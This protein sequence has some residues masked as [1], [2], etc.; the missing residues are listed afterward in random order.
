[1][2]LHE[3]NLQR[4]AADIRAQ[5]GEH[6]DG[7]FE[8]T[9]AAI[10]CAGCGATKRADGPDAPR[11]LEAMLRGWA[12]SNGEPGVPDLCPR[13][14]TALNAAHARSEARAAL[15]RLGSTIRRLTR[16]ESPSE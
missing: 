11:A 8:M 5:I 3:T 10:V 12:I 6:H 15:G 14:V 7:P 13:C 1:M 9:F 4:R 16:R 2:P